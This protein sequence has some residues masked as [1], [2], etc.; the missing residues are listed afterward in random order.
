MMRHLP[1]RGEVASAPVTV[2]LAAGC[3]AEIS[4]K[5]APSPASAEA[6]AQHMGLAKALGSA[7]CTAATDPNTLL[8][9]YGGYTSKVSGALNEPLRFPR[10]GPT[11]S[12]SKSPSSC[13]GTRSA[14][15]PWTFQGSALP[16][17]GLSD[18]PAQ[19]APVEAEFRE[20]LRRRR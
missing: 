16:R 4:S 10:P 15:V 19:A 14:R 17:L 13:S 5:P 9:R 8:G 12:R 11:P 20:A 6:I 18:T 7:A 1:E 3:G 2:A